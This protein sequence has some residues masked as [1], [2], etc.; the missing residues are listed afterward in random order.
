MT[1]LEPGVIFKKTSLYISNL[2]RDSLA[3]E[4]GIDRGK[5]ALQTAA[6]F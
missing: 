6:S 4:P 5:H 3:N 2:L 1:S